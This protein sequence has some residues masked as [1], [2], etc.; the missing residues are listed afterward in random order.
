MAELERFI[1]SDAAG[2]PFLVK[3]GL[4]HVQFETIHP[5]LDGNGR[6]GRLLIA[7]MLCD[8]GVLR[9]PM[10]YLS[11]FFKTH[12]P[13]YYELL[14]RVREAGDWEAW[15]E[16]FLTGIIETSEQAA[17]TAGR[18]LTLFEQDRRR[19]ESLGRAAASALRVHELLQSRPVIGIPAAEAAL[20]LSAPTVGKA[21]RHLT[22]LEIVEEI[23]GRQRGRTYVYRGFLDILNE[24]TAPLPR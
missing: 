18:C 13:Q 4:V 20:G 14:Q 5:F 22:D 17:D 15:L 21:I 1:H 3:V 19:I 11:L 7:L 2:T 8:R 9:A 23:T 6:I 10:L 16:F 24:G 12:R